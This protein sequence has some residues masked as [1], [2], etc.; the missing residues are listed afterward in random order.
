MPLT[1]C[2]PDFWFIHPVKCSLEN[3][4]EVCSPHQQGME[5]NSLTISKG[6]KH[7]FCLGV[8]QLCWAPLLLLLKCSGLLYLGD[9]DFNNWNPDCGT[10]SQSSLDLQFF[11]SSNLLSNLPAEFNF[12]SQRILQDSSALKGLN[13]HLMVHYTRPFK[14]RI[15]RHYLLLLSSLRLNPTYSTLECPPD[16]LSQ[17]LFTL[18]TPSLVFYLA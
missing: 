11:S 17:V 9:T 8:K 7:L 15:W 14:N 18:T 6:L 4:L 1:I 5:I 2:T 12:Q 3:V 10:T 13:S 16:T